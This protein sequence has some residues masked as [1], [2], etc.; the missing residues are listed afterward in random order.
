MLLFP[1]CKINLG[2]RIVSRR[3]DGF[4]NLESVFLPVPLCDALEAVFDSAAPDGPDTYRFSGLS[5]EGAIED[6]IVYKAVALFRSLHPL[7]A[8]QVHLHKVIPTGAGLGGGSADG[9][10]ML[11]LCNQLAGSP[12]SEEVL[13]EAAAQL[14]SD[15]PF[16]ILN[17]PA[18]VTGRG[19]QL[20]PF[21]LQLPACWLVVVH[22]GLHISTREAFSGIRPAPAENDLRQIL[23]RPPA[24]WK[25][26]LKND[27]QEGLAR[28]YPAIGGLID[29]LYRQGA[30]YASLTGSGSAVYGFFSSPPT[31]DLPGEYF[32]FQTFL[33]K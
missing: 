21:P 1:N 10:F 18:Y 27:F 13:L 16:F 8:L 22:P 20:A 14:G 6:N 25:N 30:D 15:C 4:H 31:L 9:A 19:E 17:K 3:A 26:E 23:L 32:V 7:K 5:I 11:L 24:Q 28:Q 12:L 29:S 33:G 2:L